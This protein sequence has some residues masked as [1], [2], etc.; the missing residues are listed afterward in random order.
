MRGRA[1]RQPKMLRLVAGRAVSEGD[2]GGLQIDLRG[3][4][5]AVRDIDDVGRHR[6]D[7]RSSEAAPTPA[8]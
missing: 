5:S 7:R 3:H 2:R 4:V 6:V 8:H 1:K